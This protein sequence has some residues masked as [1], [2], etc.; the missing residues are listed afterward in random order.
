[1]VLPV[2]SIDE[3]THSFIPSMHM[4]FFFGLALRVGFRR[5]LVQCQLGISR[6]SA[7]KG[8]KQMSRLSNGLFLRSIHLFTLSNCP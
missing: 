6:R 5:C 2:F 4:A 8:T 1:M 3:R 7:E